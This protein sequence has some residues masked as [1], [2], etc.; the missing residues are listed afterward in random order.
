VCHFWSITR[1]GW[2][3]ISGYIKYVFGDGRSVFL[4]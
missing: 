3:S 4:A 2:V 1:V